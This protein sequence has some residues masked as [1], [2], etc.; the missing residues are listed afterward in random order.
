[1]P[2]R[3]SRLWTRWRA[4]E[5]QLAGS[6][7]ESLERLTREAKADMADPGAPSPGPTVS[8]PKPWSGTAAPVD[9]DMA[10]QVVA[11][12]RP[13]PWCWARRSFGQPAHRLLSALVAGSRGGAPAKGR[14]CWGPRHKGGARCGRHRVAGAAGGCEKPQDSAAGHASPLRRP[15]S[16]KLFIRTLRCRE[17][18]PRCCWSIGSAATPGALHGGDLFRQGS[19]PLPSRYAEQKG[20]LV[21]IGTARCRGAVSTLSAAGKYLFLLTD[22]PASKLADAFGAPFLAASGRPMPKQK[23][24]TRESLEEIARRELTSLQ[25][26]CQKQLQMK[27]SF[28][29]EAEVGGPW[30]TASPRTRG[31]CPEGGGG[32]ALPGPQ[33][34]EAPQSAG[35]GGGTAFRGRGCP[36]GGVHPGRS[37]RAGGEKDASG[38]RRPLWLPSRRSFPKLWVCSQ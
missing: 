5:R 30:R 2:S 36:S 16:E 25:E 20:M 10:F 12:Q 26:R 32:P 1:M 11:R 4:W 27:L 9:M 24:F 34:G 6:L 19:I 3:R 23:P 7:Q 8:T 21:E 13:A 31:L 28:R 18:P 33:R 14:R 29:R 38:S 35:A 17:K 15:S 37:H 22:Q